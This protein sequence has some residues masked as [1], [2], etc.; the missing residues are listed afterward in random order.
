M[1]GLSPYAV[2]FPPRDRNAWRVPLLGGG[3]VDDAV[4]GCERAGD[5]QGLSPSSESP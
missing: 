3:S 1:Q 4:D 5:V 2:T